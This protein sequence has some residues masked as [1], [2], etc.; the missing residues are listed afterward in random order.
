MKSKDIWIKSWKLEIFFLFLNFK[1][2]FFLLKTTETEIFF[3]EKGDIT[4]YEWKYGEPPVQIEKQETI[5][6]ADKDE[7][8]FF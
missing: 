8:I 1:I 3:S 5:I 7:V 4:L 2:I 6:L